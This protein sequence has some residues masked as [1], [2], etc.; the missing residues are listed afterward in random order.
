MTGALRSTAASC[1]A[2][3]RNEPFAPTIVD[4]R[5]RV[6]EPPGYRTHV[7]TNSV[8]AS[9]NFVVTV[10]CDVEAAGMKALAAISVVLDRLP[11]Y[12]P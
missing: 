11:L 2:W 7:F 9:S 3:H 5:T 6:E 1:L 8:T 4:A 10:D 12:H